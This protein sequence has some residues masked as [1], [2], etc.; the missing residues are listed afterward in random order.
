MWG[1]DGG[2]TRLG[3]R[4]PRS[5]WIK[6]A[7]SLFW[8]STVLFLVAGLQLTEAA[9]FRVVALSGQHA[10]GTPSSAIFSGFDNP[11]LND[12]GKVAF[13]A[14]LKIGD[15]GVSESNF[16]GI[17]SGWY[18][19]QSLVARTGSQ[20][21]G[22]AAGQNFG[23]FFERGLLLNDAGQV[24]FDADLQLGVGGV[25]V[26]NQK[27]IWSQ[28]NGALALVARRGDAAPGAPVGAVFDDVSTP[29]FNNS[30]HVAFRGQL[31]QFVGGVTSDDYNGVWS[32]GGGTLDLVVRQGGHANGFTLGNVYEQ[33]G[34]P[35][36][37]N[38][39]RVTFSASVMPG[40]SGIWYEQGVL[41]FSFVRSGTQAPG[42][43]GGTNFVSF[44]VS[45]V[46]D[47]GRTAF[48]GQLPGIG[49]L[50]VI[51]HGI[52]SNRSG[53]LALITRQGLPAPGTANGEI[54]VDF[55]QPVMN[56]AGRIAFTGGLVVPS[57]GHYLIVGDG[58]WSDAQGPLTLV[59]REGEPAPGAPNGEIFRTIGDKALNARGQLALEAWISGGSG[60]WAQDINGVLRAIALPGDTIDVDSG[61]GVDLRTI[62][63]A[64][65][66]SGSGNED[67]RASAFNDRGQLAF[68]VHFTDE[69]WGVFISNRVST[70][71]E[72]YG[73]AGAAI[74]M[75][76]LIGGR[77]L[78][79]GRRAGAILIR[80]R[81]A[82]SSIFTGERAE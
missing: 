74:G 14:N 53:S 59:A 18:G 15:G 82:C 12:S 1:A 21:P 23:A 44:G 78:R 40:G 8:L 31:R 81:H 36:L 34:D 54:F 30:G 72:P 71:P 3:Q 4:V 27:G 43:P 47:A 60:V 17:W 19:S 2:L 73:L 52:W 66:V 6:R 57:G 37:N 11:V 32:E 75:L 35:L 58:I 29:V 39:G 49:P 20:A 26:L 61:P 16:R 79:S 50:G 22:A 76:C 7:P 28:R 41:P 9:D 45:A 24:A 68:R 69:T 64:S 70:V 13:V 38:N 51:N 10:P 55:Y 80:R 63:N 48:R 25:T 33:F 67:G 46:N 65:F 56:S 77:L 62:L 42:L 5:T